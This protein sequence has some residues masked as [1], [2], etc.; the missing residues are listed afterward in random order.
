MDQNIG[1]TFGQWTI[2]NEI[3]DPRSGKHYE[4][5]CS[6]GTIKTVPWQS[7]RLSR[8]TRCKECKHFQTSS[9]NKMIGKKFGKWLVLRLEGKLHNSYSYL[10]RCDCGEEKV[11]HGPNLR[12]GHTTQCT[13]C[14]NRIKALNNTTHGLAGTSTYKIWC[15]MHQRCKNPKTSYY[16][17]YGGRGISVC[18]RWNTFENFLRDMGERP[19]KMDL[20]RIDNNGNYEPGNCRWIS[21]KENCQNTSRR[22][23]KTDI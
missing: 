9:F 4:C 22:D 6:C 8:S 23:K 15:Q 12:Y 5:Q 13:S 2:L 18:D 3:D 7:L 21:H 1:K 20:D 16:A 19:H 10:C 14:S 11:L 17:R